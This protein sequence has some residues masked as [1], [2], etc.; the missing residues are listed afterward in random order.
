MVGQDMR[1]QCLLAIFGIVLSSSLEVVAQVDLSL[2]NALDIEAVSSSS[3]SG[4]IR[5]GSGCL[6][7]EVTDL[8]TF[9]ETPIQFTRIYRSRNTMRSAAYEV[10]GA[11]DSWSHNWNYELRDLKGKEEGLHPLTLRLPNGDS[12]T[13]R[14]LDEEAKIRGAG[15]GRGDRLYEWDDG[16]GHTLVRSSGQEL[17]FSRVSYPTYRLEA[18]RDRSGQYWW[19]SYDENGDLLRVLNR[20]GRY[21]EFEYEENPN[22]L[23]EEDLPGESKAARNSSI[24]RLKAVT[25]NDGRRVDYQY[26]SWKP[27]GI[28]MLTEVSYP[29]GEQASYG[30][31]NSLKTSDADFEDGNR[32]LLEFAIDPM[33][34]DAG[35]QLMWEYNYEKGFGRG[36]SNRFLAQG[37]VKA[38]KSLFSQEIV[39]EL[40]YGAGEE[41]IVRGSD[42]SETYRKFANGK[43]VEEK[44]PEG[45]ATSYFYSDG[46]RGSLERVLQPDDSETTYHR[47]DEGRVTLE[48]DGE[49]VVQVAEYGEF[50][51]TEWEFGQD[52]VYTE[53]AYN[54]EDLVTRTDYPDGSFSTVAYN[55][56]NQR[57]SEVAQNGAQT[58]Y[59]YYAEEAGGFVGD[60]KAITAADG[61][62]T[63]FTYDGAGLK[64]SE[65]D[66]LGFT[67]QWTY[68]WRGN[69]LTETEPDNSSKV[70]TY[71]D[72]GK[73]ETATNEL[74]ATT[75]AAYD[76]F[77]RRV[78]VTGP[79]GRVTRYTYG[80]NAGCDSCAGQA[81]VAKVE[82]PSGKVVSYQ[83]DKDG[84]RTEERVR[85]N[86]TETA[87]TRF[88]YN[89]IG[90]KIS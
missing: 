10:F 63:S 65:T 72:F 59:T 75:T 35:A 79:L 85:I 2:P 24:R 46:G 30:Y 39:V 29:G 56:S 61:G 51:T 62:V 22:N 40:P 21:L 44:T 54:D 45:R 69:V 33:I 42:G 31:C 6:I 77:N 37:I 53:F 81:Q 80:L 43:L 12:R 41:S 20:F 87:I 34:G 9:G 74:G 17:Y 15:S 5:V 84:N 38:E 90:N 67:T 47:D 60:L 18:I 25:S 55:A 50:S 16:N 8:E 57:V 32:P 1:D 71:T 27:G 23:T 89:E 36:R 13:Y 82:Y 58:L 14:G 78:S 88:A 3:G 48:L 76:E 28:E 86:G 52:G 73:L 66:P 19:C 7:R 11:S 70:F 26:R 4:E 49:G 68:D 64:L 83:Y